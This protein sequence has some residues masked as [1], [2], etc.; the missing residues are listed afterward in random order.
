MRSMDKRYMMFYASSHGCVTC[1]RA[2]L[3]SKVSPSCVSDTQH[4]TALS[5]A[6]WGASAAGGNHDTKDVVDILKD[7]L[8][9]EKAEMEDP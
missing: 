7:A 3:S 5:F 8:A 2:L 1:V 4:Y 9:V 6:E